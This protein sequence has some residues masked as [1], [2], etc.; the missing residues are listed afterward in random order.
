MDFT[1]LQPDIENENL[2]Q[3]PKSES[4]DVESNKRD[5]QNEASV[6]PSFIKENILQSANNEVND[7]LIISKVNF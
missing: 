4:F 1:N 2:H 5:L 7:K 6:Y 3:I